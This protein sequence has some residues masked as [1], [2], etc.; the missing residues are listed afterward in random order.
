M[1]FGLTFLHLLMS[2]CRVVMYQNLKVD[3]N[4][5]R[6]KCQYGWKMMLV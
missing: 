2:T 3:Y 4:Y 5:I 6:K 1:S